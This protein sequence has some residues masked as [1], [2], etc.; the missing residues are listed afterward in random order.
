M[1]RKTAEQDIILMRREKIASMLLRLKMSQREIQ[2]ALAKGGKESKGQ[3]LNPDTKKPY[4]LKTI[5]IKQ[6]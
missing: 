5:Y 3:M 1:A 2:R 6:D 4:T